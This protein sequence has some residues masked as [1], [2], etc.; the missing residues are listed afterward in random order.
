MQESTVMLDCRTE[1]SDTVTDLKHLTFRSA[2]KKIRRLN[3]GVE[4][5]FRVKKRLCKNI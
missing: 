3:Q 4:I 5:R 2:Q 1:Q